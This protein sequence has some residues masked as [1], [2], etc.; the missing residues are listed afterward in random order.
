MERLNKSPPLTNNC[1]TGS[2]AEWGIIETL[3][4]SPSR[5]SSKLRRYEERR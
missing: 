4:R 3:E 5:G 1:S 2:G